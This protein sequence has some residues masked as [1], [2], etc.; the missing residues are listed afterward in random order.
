L[1]HV[2]Q[3]HTIDVL[4]L[5]MLQI[6]FWFNPLFFLLKKAVQLNHEFLADDKVISSHNNISRYQYLL[7]NKAAWKNEYYLASNLNYSLTKK[8]LL[9][10]IT[11]N[12]R[13]NILLKK[14]AILP[15]LTGLLFVFANRIEAQTIKKKPQVIEEKAK[16]LMQDQAD[17]FYKKQKGLL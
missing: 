6:L 17:A 8:R 13:T 9:M 11:T 2:T 10:M 12:Y 4:I 15:L 16:E 5:E 3:K 1:A 14:L 7:L